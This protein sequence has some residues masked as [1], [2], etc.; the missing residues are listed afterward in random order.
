MHKH[1]LEAIRNMEPAWEKV[2]GTNFRL[3]EYTDAKG[4]KRPEYQLT[5]SQCLYVA[6]KF[7]D[8]A[9][10]KLVQRWEELERNQELE[11]AKSMLTPDFIIGLA[12]RI[13]EVEAEKERFQLQAQLQQK[14]LQDAAPKVQFYEEALQTKDLITASQVAADLGVSAIKLNMW[15]FEQQF[16]HKAGGVWIPS[17]KIKGLGY[18]KSRI[19]TYYDSKGEMHSTQHFYFTQAGREFVM[20]KWKAYHKY[21]EVMP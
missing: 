6:T 20:R 9:R 18:M 4:E 11:L 17:A 10:A 13:K 21:Q 7:N 19:H 12:N 8:E 14:E 2:N 5:K 15:L 1:V 3:V 16:Q